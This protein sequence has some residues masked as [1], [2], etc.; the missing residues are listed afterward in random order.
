MVVACCRVE[1]A[2]LAVASVP[3]AKKKISHP[4]KS[5]RDARAVRAAYEE[6]CGE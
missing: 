4:E 3:N 2:A 5:E 6:R 1:G